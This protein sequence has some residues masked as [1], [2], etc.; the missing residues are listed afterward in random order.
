MSLA[1][2]D[3]IAIRAIRAKTKNAADSDKLEQMKHGDKA[4]GKKIGLDRRAA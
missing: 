4:M 3:V 2:P 1:I